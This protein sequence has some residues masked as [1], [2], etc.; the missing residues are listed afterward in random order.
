MNTPASQP[1]ASATQVGGDH[2]KDMKIQ[3][4]RFI[5]ANGIP[6]HEGCA[7]KYLCRHAAK[8]GRQDLEKARHYIDLILEEDYPEET[9]AEYSKEDADLVDGKLLKLGD[10]YEWR[11]KNAPWSGPWQIHKGNVNMPFPPGIEIRRSGPPTAANPAT[12]APEYS[13]QPAVHADQEKFREAQQD[14][15]C[16]KNAHTESPQEE[17]GLCDP[18]E[19]KEGDWYETQ[20]TDEKMNRGWNGPYQAEASPV[21][22]TDTL[23]Y[24]RCAPP[25]EQVCLWR[26]EV[27]KE[28]Y[29]KFSA[30]YG[31]TFVVMADES[32]PDQCPGCKRK[33]VVE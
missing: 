11:D 29:R 30:C 1:K 5:R 7:I 10:W 2:Y 33:V 22:A 6:Y 19:L 16:A 21:W 14:S 13:G 18:R 24:R 31:K 32:Q 3:P 23:R 15:V 27:I 17:P 26:P 8:G 25:A 9:T 20:W 4:A 12:V 28:N